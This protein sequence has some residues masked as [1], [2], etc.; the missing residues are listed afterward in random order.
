MEKKFGKSI[1]FII[2]FFILSGVL[3]N[4]TPETI[5]PCS[6]ITK[7]EAQ[8]LIGEKVKQPKEK[9]IKGMAAGKQ[10]TYLTSAPIADRGIVGSLTIIIYDA[11]T[12]K[13]Y[14]SFFKS[15]K[16]YFD[17]V[18][19][20]SKKSNIE[21]VEIKE[22]GKKAY[23]QPNIYKLHVLTENLYITLKVMGIKKFTGKD[24]KELD[25]KMSEFRKKKSVDAIKNYV[26]PKLK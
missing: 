19:G 12:M 17:K 3:I 11:K 13:E 16:E 9:L 2:C 14:N 25:K 10:C 5:K 21:M 8:K 22:C 4:A 7:Q 20:A 18:I 1:Y 6:L 23:W 15:P 26:L 24:R